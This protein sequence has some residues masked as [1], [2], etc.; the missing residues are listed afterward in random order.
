MES[1]AFLTGIEDIHGPAVDC[2]V[3]M[4]KSG[5]G[6]ER[7]SRR[8]ALLSAPELPLYGFYFSSYSACSQWSSA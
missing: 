1:N 8:G 2:T 5:P 6:A 4:R 7:F 3:V